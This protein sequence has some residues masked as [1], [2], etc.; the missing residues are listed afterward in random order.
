MSQITICCRLIAPEDPRQ[1][2]W[3]RMAERNTPLINEALKQLPQHP[4]F[5]KWQRKGKVPDTA[6]KR[7]IDDLKADPRFVDQPVWYYISAQKHVT[8]IFR[9]WLASKQRKQ[10]KLEGKRRLLEVLKADITLAELAQCSLEDLQQEAQ[11]ILAQVVKTDLVPTLWR[12]YAKA[13]QAQRKCAIAYLLKRNGKLEP[14]KENIEQLEKR[15]NKTEIFIQRLTAQIDSSLP[16]GR[17]LTDCMRELALTEGVQSSFL[18]DAEYNDWRDVLTTEP[19]TFPFPIIYETVETLIW[20]RD[21]KNRILVRFSGSGS[22]TFKVYC[23]KPHYH[24][25]ERFLTDQQ[26]KKAGSNQHSAGLFTLRSAKLM[27]V[28]SKKHR[29]EQHPWNRFH[30][31]LTCTVDTRLWT[32]EGTQIVNREK[33]AKTTKATQAMQGKASLTK[34]QQDYLRRLESTLQRLQAPYPR[35]SRPLYQGQDEILVGISMGLD[36]P[37]TLAVV[38]VLTD[39]TLAYRSIKQLLGDQYPLLQRARQEKSKVSH[40][41]HRQRRKGGRRL[42]QESNLGK[43]I[44]RILAK[45]IVAIAQQYQASSIVLPNL[46]HIRDAIEAEVSQRAQAKVPD[47]VE[48]QRQYAKAYRVQV[49]QWPFHRLQQA[50]TAKAEQA[51]IT[52][53]QA[54]QQSAGS[55]Q[56]KAKELAWQGYRDRQNKKSKSP[57]STKQSYSKA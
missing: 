5:P 30:L 34:T 6:A 26:V 16:K 42:S 54:V 31:N 21:E 32:Q 35:P 56:D 53:E 13:E 18:E 44:D 48:G 25:F 23:D 51:G 36:K 41:G 9:S 46:N 15:R 43:Q 37:A 45:Q 47:F 55:A 20:S 50:I 28:P 1:V 22:H 7:I 27:W 10:W 14:K 29:A 39:E 38:N 4:D 49:H 33:A 12:E 17:D 8:Y 19:A 40:E 3:Q 57:D 24:W 11:N 2:L 52:I